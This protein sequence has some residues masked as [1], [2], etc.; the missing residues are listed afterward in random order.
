M[1]TSHEALKEL[2]EKEKKKEEEE[3]KQKRREE[4]E[5]KKIEKQEEKARKD[6]IRQK[7]QTDK[8]LKKKTRK[9]QTDVEHPDPVIDESDAEPESS[10]SGL[11]SHEISNNEC[12]FCFGLY[13]DNFSATG[14][15]QREWIQ[16]TRVTCKKWM[17][18]DC[19]S[20]MYVCG[21]CKM[22]LC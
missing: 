3:A 14:R 9:K 22:L 2:I 5:R 11:Q 8:A 7:K 17:H 19:L 18:Y 15:L 4:R 12:A 13:D 6:E 1:L 20:D 21:L 16:C 10:D